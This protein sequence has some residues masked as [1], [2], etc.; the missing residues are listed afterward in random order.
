[1]DSFLVHLFFA[2]KWIEILQACFICHKNKLLDSII[3]VYRGQI[4]E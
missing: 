4:L 3:Q 2:L 1:M